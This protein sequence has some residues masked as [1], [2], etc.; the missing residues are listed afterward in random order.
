MKTFVTISRNFSGTFPAFHYSEQEASDRLRGIMDTEWEDYF[1]DPMPDDW[2]EAYEMLRDMSWEPT[3]E[4]HSFTID[5]ARFQGEATDDAEEKCRTCG[6]TYQDDGDGYDGECP[7]CADRSFLRDEA[8]DAIYSATVPVYATVYVRAPNAETA[9]QRVI[10]LS[11]DGFEVSDGT[12]NIDGRPYDECFEEEDYRG[13]SPAMT[14][15]EI[16]LFASDMDVAYQPEEKIADGD[17]TN[18]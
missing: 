2:I 3:L 1:D 11:F 13:V 6:E 9:A 4:L 17:T 16:W 12:C 18:E 10:A 8:G 5:P 14:F 7:S 15:G